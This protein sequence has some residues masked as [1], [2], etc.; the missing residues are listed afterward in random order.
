M[1]PRV[2]SRP[3]QLLEFLGVEVPPHL[4][5]HILGD[6]GGPIEAAVPV[7]SE[8]DDAAPAVGR[9]HHFRHQS[10]AS[11]RSTSTEMVERSIDART[12]SSDWSSA[13][14]WPSN[15]STANCGFV[16]SGTRSS[17]SAVQ[18]WDAR[19]RCVWAIASSTTAQLLRPMRA[20]SPRRPKH[21]VPPQ[22]T[23]RNRRHRSCTGPR[24]C[25][26]GS[27]APHRTAGSLR[28]DCRHHG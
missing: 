28:G 24:R 12:P 10:R 8:R 16:K 5:D 23:L 18:A 11:R 3:H 9:V 22:P 6:C 2:R 15:N 25:A 21:S 17:Y 7:V 4:A 20:G 14:C 1:P 13:P 19:P 26:A 27:R